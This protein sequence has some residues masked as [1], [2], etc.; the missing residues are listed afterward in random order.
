[1]TSAG[2]FVAVDY[3]NDQI[4]LRLKSN[5]YDGVPDEIVHNIAEGLAEMVLS[6]TPVQSS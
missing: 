5:T 6:H 3:V 1:L 2:L 4:D